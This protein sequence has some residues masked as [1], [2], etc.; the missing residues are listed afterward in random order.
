MNPSNFQLLAAVIAA[1]KNH[2]LVGRTRLQKTVKLLQRLGYPSRYLYKIFFYGPYS[3]GVQSDIAVLEMMGLV[4]E[5]ERLGASGNYFVLRADEDCLLP[6]VEE[7]ED[8]IRLMEEA[9]SV[10]LELAATYD[11]FRAWGADHET[12]LEK[13]RRKKGAK[14]EGGN[15]ERALELLEQ[16]GLPTD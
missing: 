9:D 6:A 5:E 8:Q 14:C 3:D 1:H 15:E 10:V 7:F 4:E 12:A 16:L 13:L 2:Q 11:A